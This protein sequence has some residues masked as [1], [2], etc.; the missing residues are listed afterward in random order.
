M[1]ETPDFPRLH[2]GVSACLAGQPVRFNGGHAQDDFVNHALRDVAD[3]TL[4]CPEAPV[5]GTPR[6][7]I[8][9]V[10]VDGKIHIQGVKSQQDVTERVQ[11][12]SAEQAQ[13]VLTSN[14][15]GVVVKSRSPTCGLERIKV[16]HPDGSWYGSRDPLT[17]GVFTARLQAADPLL[18]IEDE[19]RLRDAWLREN[20]ML[21]VYTRARWRLFLAQAPTVKG[22][23]DF[24]RRHKFLLMAKN[25][26]L[27]REM[28]PLV[29]ETRNANLAEKLEAYGKRLHQVMA[30][31]STRKRLRNAFDHLYGYY[32][33]RLDPE[34]KTYYARTM[35]EFMDGIVPLIAVVK[36]LEGFQHRYPNAYLADQV[37]WNPY[38]PQLA[39][40]TDVSATR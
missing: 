1:L 39:L 28:G 29:A 11:H 17:T 4:F 22:L 15:D 25:E 23:Q 14:P 2:L 30:T 27:Y 24:H 5:L 33:T 18:P 3:F 19:G 38:P 36:V 21:R 10:N 13:K 20:F 8:R 31:L 9:L 26:Q 7:T 37:F 40:R 35:Q 6:E 12:S 16:Y 34:E 32:K